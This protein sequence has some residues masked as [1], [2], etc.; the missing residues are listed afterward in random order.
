[1]EAINNMAATAARA[2]WGDGSSS[3][4]P[5]SGRTG[6]TSKGE[7]YDAGNMDPPSANGIDNE[8]NGVNPSRESGTPAQNNGISDGGFD[9]NNSTD[10]DTTNAGNAAGFAKT[11][12]VAVESDDTPENPSTALKANT[13]PDDTTKGQ[14][15]TRSPSDPNTNPK[16][17]PTDVNDTANSDEGLNEAQKLDGPGPKPVSELAKEHGGDAGD[18]STSSVDKVDN[19]KEEETPGGG[20][21]ESKGTGEQ[22]VKSNGLQA[23]GGDFDATKPGAGREADRLLEVK[24]IHN[25]TSP[26]TKV[27]QDSGKQ[28]KEKKSFGQKIKDK[29]H[30]H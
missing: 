2:V 29:L 17:A 16:S 3:Q 12:G 25:P 30:R 1:M 26:D 13:V 19:K 18:S 22:Y 21:E 24:G 27:G 15:D 5:V 7:P 14:N 6:D 28:E 9:K 8:I 11:T 23:D 20:I 4:E 10:R